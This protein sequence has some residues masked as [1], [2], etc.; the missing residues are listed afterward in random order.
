V[1]ELMPPA[2]KTDLAAIPEGANVKVITTD[3]L[4]AATLK[5]L[6]KGKLEIRPGQANQLRFMSRL[7]PDFIG[8]QLAKSSKSLIPKERR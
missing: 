2:V 1:I 3:E 6:A 5:A 8:G 4:V 7:A